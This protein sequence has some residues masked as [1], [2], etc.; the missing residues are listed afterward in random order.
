MHAKSLQSCLTLCDP[1]DRSH[2]APLSVGSR[3]EYE[4]ELLFPSPGDLPD[5]GIEPT[6]PVSSALQVDS[7]PLNHRRSPTYELIDL[8]IS[9]VSMRDLVSLE[10]AA[11]SR[12]SV[13]LGT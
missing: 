2:Q 7:L 10:T 12:R 1:V 3:Q 4:N 5:L 8:I 6:S 11:E 13:S 9:I